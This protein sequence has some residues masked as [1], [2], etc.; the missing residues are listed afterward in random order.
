MTANKEVLPHVVIVG[1]GF[2]GL[3]AAQALN[4]VPIR[5]TVIDR[6]NHH[7]FQPL[8]YQV[9]TAGL[10]PADIAAPIRHIVS[11]QKNTNVLMAEVIDIDTANRLVL[12]RE[13]EPMPYDYLILATGARHSYFGKEEWEVNAPGLKTL[14]DATRIR[15]KV[16]G[17]FEQAEMEEDEELRR[18][19]L[20]FA[21][22]GG[23][24]TGAEM[25]GA[26]AELARRALARDFRH[27]DPRSTRI[28]LLEASPRILGNF[29]AYLAERAHKALENMGVEVRT[30]GAVQEIDDTGLTVGFE[31]IG[32]R[33]V[34]W[35]AGV[36]ASPAGQW[37]NAPMDRNRRVLVEPDLSVPGHPEIFVIGDTAT[38]LQDGQPLPGVA[39]AAMQQGRYV[40][41]VIRARVLKREPPPPFRYRNKGNMATI[42]RK[43]AIADFGKFGMSGFPA[44]LF[45]LGLHV[46]FLI[47]FRNRLSVMIQWAW[48]YVTYERGARLITTPPL[49]DNTK[50]RLTQNPNT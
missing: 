21:I 19:L 20:T 42:G 50:A 12:T 46:Y 14:T 33:T 17:A 41:D 3:N 38:R 40:G 10:S 11:R 47:G 22:V 6:T 4:G 29:P 45:W 9:A 34:V 23:G 48:A 32:C 1:G 28:L 26:I 7:V 31:R 37:L 43:F 16:L 13:D 30:G 25:A 24:P 8:L 5:V 39:P 27:I 2:G 44:W 18:E 35:A 15:E 49:R 36:L